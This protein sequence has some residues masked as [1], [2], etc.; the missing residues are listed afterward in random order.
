M[1][2]REENTESLDY[3]TERRTLLMGL[4]VLPAIA[5]A[6][7]AAPAAG[8]AAPPSDNPRLFEGRGP[9]FQGKTMARKMQ[10]LVEHE[11]YRELTAIYAH[12]VAQGVSIADLYTDDA[13]FII[14]YPG[15]EPIVTTGGRAFLDKHFAAT[16]KM[17]PAPLPMIHNHLVRMNGDNGHGICS[18]ELR[19]TENGKSMIGSGYYLDTLRRENGRLRFVIR[20]MNF[21]HWVP[22]QQGWSGEGHA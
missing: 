5:G 2:T 6:A 8:A 9:G 20:D 11:E 17:N 19:M 18:N 21:I 1:I 3:L 7:E 12:R 15:R 4:L 14:R 10:E 13:S 16:A 22:L